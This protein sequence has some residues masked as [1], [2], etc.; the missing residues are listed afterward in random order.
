[1]LAICD[2]KTINQAPTNSPQDESN[3]EM[4]EAE[5]SR[6]PPHCASKLYIVSVSQNPENAAGT[7][8][9]NRRSVF[10]GTEIT[11]KQMAML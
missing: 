4:L 2:S 3:P 1:M 9:R 11:L 6:F 5:M 8:L 10:E 7:I